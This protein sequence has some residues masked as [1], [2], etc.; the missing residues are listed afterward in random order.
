MKFLFDLDE[1]LVGGDMISNASS[2]LMRNGLIDRQYT[3]KDSLNYDL[4]DLPDLVRARTLQRFSDPYYVWYKHPIPGS[5]YLLR[6]LEDQGHI[7][8]IITARP[9]PLQLETIRFLR[10]RFPSIAF[11]SGINFVNSTDT[12]GDKGM[13]TKIDFLRKALPDYYFDDCVEYC[14]QAKSLDIKTYL[15]SNK[16]TPWNHE[17][18]KEQLAALDPVRVLRNV[19]FFPETS[20]YNG[21]S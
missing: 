14:I 1:T 16:H 5:F 2:E 7:T 20:A 12:V 19:A 17:F 13:P 8:G 11:E 15:I 6:F 21:N 4:R 9:K 3:N 10:A 18:A